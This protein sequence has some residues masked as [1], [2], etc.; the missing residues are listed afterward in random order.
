MTSI[1]GI[2]YN[3]NSGN[4][5]NSSGIIRYSNGGKINNADGNGACGLGTY[6]GTIP[7]T[8]SACPP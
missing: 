6:T 1:T 5:N 3:C 7:I 2:L 4:I 8:G